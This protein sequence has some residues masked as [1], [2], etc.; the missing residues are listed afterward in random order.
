MTPFGNKTYDTLKLIALVWLPALVALYTGVATLWGLGHI[1]QVAGTISVVDTFLG[2]VLG[3]SSSNYMP[4]TDGSLEV[5]SSNIGA[6]RLVFETSVEDMAAKKF[7]TLQVTPMASSTLPV[8]SSV[9][10][11]ASP[12]LPPATS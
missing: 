5:D 2:V 1:P 7:I 3:V 11:M 10:P 8:T 4:K 6:A 9:A 12:S